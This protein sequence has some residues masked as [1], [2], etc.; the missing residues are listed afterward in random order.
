MNNINS[1]FQQNCAVYSGTLHVNV[2]CSF[3]LQNF[4]VPHLSTFLPLQA[5]TKESINISAFVSLLVVY[6][7]NIL[8]Q[9]WS[10]YHISPA[11]GEFD[12][13]NPVCCIVSTIHD[14]LLVDLKDNVFA[15]AH[16]SP[17]L[18]LKYSSEMQKMLKTALT[19]PRDEHRLLN[20]FLHSN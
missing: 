11:S 9:V 18:T 8:F 15:F 16:P 3:P 20:G 12:G 14:F 17:L 6:H 1:Y 5:N 4:L 13:H 7:L 2:M 19:I 10:M